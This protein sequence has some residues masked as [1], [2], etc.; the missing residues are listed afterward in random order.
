MLYSGKNGWA[1]PSYNPFLPTCGTLTDPVVHAQQRHRQKVPNDKRADPRAWEPKKVPREL[2]KILPDEAYNKEHQKYH[3]VDTIARLPDLCIFDILKFLPLQDL[4]RVAC[5]SKF[6]REYS[7]DLYDEHYWREANKQH[8]KLLEIWYAADKMW[9]EHMLHY[10]T[11]V[12]L[13]VHSFRECYDND[14][15][16]VNEAELVQ[17][18]ETVAIPHRERSDPCRD[19]CS[20]IPR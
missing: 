19:D 18:Q 9:G 11:Y 5:W 10:G 20:N 13:R 6:W 2:Q 15:T 17:A 4:R 3:A 7:S 12:T 14:Q 1:T 8:E 16:M